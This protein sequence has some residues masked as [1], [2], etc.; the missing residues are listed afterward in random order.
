MATGTAIV[1]FTDVTSGVLL[2]INNF[3][4]PSVTVYV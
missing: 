1:S 3:T 2:F 4:K